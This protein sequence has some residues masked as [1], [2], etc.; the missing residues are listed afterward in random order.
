V[1]RLLLR[2]CAPLVPILAWL[3]RIPF[4]LG[5]K[6]WRAYERQGIVPVPVHYYHPYPEESDPGLLRHWERESDLAGIDLDV[7]ASLA[8]LDEIGRSFAAECV[9]PERTD[10]PRVFHS[11]N[12]QFGYASAAVAHAMVRRLA[13]RRVI[14]VGSG[15]STHVLGGALARNARESGRSP[16]LTSI[17]PHPPEILKA[18]IPFLSRRIERRVEEVDRSLFATLERGDLLFLDSS[19]VIRYGGDVLFL[20]LE[21]LPALGTG[22]VVHIH[23]IHLPDPYPR[24]YYDES[25]Y[26]WNEQYLLQAFLCHNPRF[27][28]LL[29]CWLIHRKHDDA[30][31]RAFPAYDPERHRPGSSLWIER[32][33]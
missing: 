8:L 9:W 33:A 16:E 5:G 12:G 22:V 14:E 20:Y 27:R 15:Y 25:R 11:S 6:P 19:H 10:D 4:R 30:F 24:V 17:E 31:R 29:P 13:P 18:E 7:P 32:V 3:A 23:D 26:V 28:V 1:R 21:I 2:L